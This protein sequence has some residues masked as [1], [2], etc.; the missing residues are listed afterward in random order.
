MGHTFVQLPDQQIN[1]RKWIRQRHQCQNRKTITALFKQF[2]IWQSN[3]T[4]KNTKIRLYDS[5][6]QAVLLNGTEF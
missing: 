2:H 5:C 4:S 6:V 3:E 1:N